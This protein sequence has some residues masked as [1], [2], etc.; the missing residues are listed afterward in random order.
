MD[1]LRRHLYLIL[2]GAGGAVGIA[3]MVTGLR[4]MP[5]VN[6]EM[7]ASAQF[8]QTLGSLQ[9][10]PVN[11]RV[12]ETTQTRIDQIVAD[13]DELVKK[14]K[15]FYPYEFLLE[16]IK[17][18]VD[19][20]GEKAPKEK[21]FP[22]GTSEMR[23]KFR[24]VYAQEIQHLWEALRAGRPALDTDVTIMKEKIE[25]EE[26]RR[27]RAQ[28]TVSASD[29]G[30]ESTPAGVLTRAGIRKDP[31]ARAHLAAAQRIYCYG[32]HF[33]DAKPPELDSSLTFY[34]AMRETGKATPPELKECWEAQLAYWL[35]KDVVDAITAVNGEA[36][37]AA[38]DRDED[39]WVGIMPIK[40]VISIRTSRGYVMPGNDQFVGS[41]PGD[42]RPALPPAAQKTAFTQSASTD[43]YEVMQFSVKL[44]MDERYILRFVERVCENRF[45]VP[46]RIAFK[47]V[48]PNRRWHGKIYG[49][50]PV[51]NVV[52]DFETML[53]GEVF[54]PWMPQAVCEDYSIPCG[55]EVPTGKA[56]PAKAPPKPPKKPAKGKTEED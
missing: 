56:T 45:H 5:A 42:Y 29:A 27:K 49:S 53:L 32:V 12:L 1:L 52:M 18:T 54:R 3:L 23:D 9:S 39:R 6:T 11:Q 50:A 22:E 30:P 8:H 4:A 34:A 13:R 21:V 35:Q 37:A 33:N 40:E 19:P 24:R 7:Q 41:A 43:A 38:R 44:V 47:A 2:C 31:L 14:A 20:E 25:E 16:K 17:V 51:V 55:G 48:E 26:F 36:A 28:E 15:E 46:L 10:K